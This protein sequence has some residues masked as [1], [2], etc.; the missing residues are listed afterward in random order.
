MYCLD[1]MQI[2]QQVSECDAVKGRS[3]GS[4]RRKRPPDLKEG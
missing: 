3:G 1:K 2:L 4:G